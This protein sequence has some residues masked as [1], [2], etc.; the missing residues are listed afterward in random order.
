LGLGRPECRRGALVGQ[1]GDERRRRKQASGEDGKRPL[2]G[3]AFSEDRMLGH[4]AFS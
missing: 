4:V 1:A 3:P 2:S